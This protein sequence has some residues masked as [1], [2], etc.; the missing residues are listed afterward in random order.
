M[1]THTVGSPTL[2]KREMAECSVCAH[3]VPQSR[4]TAVNE[5]NMVSLT[6]TQL[7][8]LP[9]VRAELGGFNS[10]CP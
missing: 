1:D 2:S 5:N 10:T 3:R 8:A 6:Y 4:L 7:E 9:R